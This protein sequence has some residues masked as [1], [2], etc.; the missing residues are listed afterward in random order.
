MRFFS[1]TEAPLVHIEIL[2]DVAKAV[3]AYVRYGTLF[4]D[5]WAEGSDI[6]C[7]AGSDLEAFEQETCQECEL[8]T[9]S[10][11][12][13]MSDDE[14]YHS[15]YGDVTI[16]DSQV[17]IY[18]PCCC[19]SDSITEVQFPCRM[20]HEPETE[21]DP[22]LTLTAEFMQYSVSYEL[23]SDFHKSKSSVM[24][25][26]QQQPLTIYQDQVWT[27]NPATAIN[28]FERDNRICWGELNTPNNLLQAE[29]SFTK[30]Y[31]NQDLCSFET[32]QE[33]AN[34]LNSL[35][36]P[37]DY[38][39]LDGAV[40]VDN[41][42]KRPKAAICAAAAHT[43]GSFMLL[44]TAQASGIGPIAFVIA[45][46]YKNV[47]ITDD[48]IIDVWATEVMPIGKRLLFVSNN[49]SGLNNGLYIGQVD[50]NFNLSPC[51]LIQP[52]SLEPEAQDNKLSPV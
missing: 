8:Y 47:A 16:S 44:K 46:L 38:Y 35:A 22:D 23:T 5:T 18:S 52:P 6:P 3:E 49:Q 42:I 21:E 30:S 25:Y 19:H 43:V 29:A 10:L 32:H 11:T 26:A 4:I 9:D 13:D 50:P 40:P 17:Q 20:G 36:F 14:V 7:A 15:S 34:D 2:P 41:S 39:V 37:E 45:Y 28:T 1:P 51:E 33:N 27:A 48:N 31:A 12:I 24:Y